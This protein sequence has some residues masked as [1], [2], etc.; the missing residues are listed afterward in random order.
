MLTFAN[1]GLFYLTLAGTGR[2]ERCPRFCICDNIKHSVACVNKNLTQVPVTIPQ[3]TNKL[4]IHDNNIEMIPGGAFRPIP[5]LTHLNMQKCKIE[6]IEEGAFRGLGRLV[7]LNLAFNNIA[8]I[9][10]E[11]FDGLSFL[12]QLVLEKNRLEEIKPGAFSQLGFLNLLNLGDNFLV[13]LPDMIFQGLQQVKWICLSNNTLNIV[14]DQAFV[15][16]PTLKRLSLDHNEL[17]YLPTEALSKLSGVI[18]LD[19]G[20]NPLTFIGEEAVQMDSLKQ[21]F[22]NDMALQDVSHK[23]FEKSPS[24]SLID[25]QNNQLKVMQPLTGLKQIKMVNLTG[26]PIHCNCYMRPFK[27]WADKS[28]IQANIV[29]SSPISF[30]GEHLESL[31]AIDLKCAS[32]ILEVEEDH[33]PAPT[34]STEESTPCPQNCFC[35]PDLLHVSCENQGH[36]KIPKGFS[37]NTHLLDLR[38]NKFHTVPKNSFSDMKNLVSLHLQNCHI[39]KLQPGAFLGM[40]KMIY[41]YLSN[42]KISAINSAAFEGIPQLTYLYLDHNRFPKVP[43]EAFKLL[44]NLFALHLQYNSIS[45]LSDD[46]MS[47]AEKLHWL[48]LTGN[49]IK[50]VAP[51]ALCGIEGLEKLHLDE[52]LLSEIP[53]SSLLNLPMLEELKLS[54]NPIK[55]IGNGTFLPLA[56]SLQHL[57]LDNLGLEKIAAGAFAGIGPGIRRLYLE[58]NKLPNLPSMNNFTRL[59]VINLDNNPFVCNCQLLPLRRWIDKLNLKVGATCELPANVHG[60]R[61]KDILFKTCLR[62]KKEKPKPTIQKVTNNKKLTKRKR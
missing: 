33:V 58:N 53:T 34:M 11:S 51:L 47:G 18:R 40:R 7:Y 14:A 31:R 12:Q 62:W 29:C 56:S 27:E 19:L 54:K 1:L 50:Y 60:Q 45:F 44:P 59:E 57:Y 24:L 20:W 13:Y 42:N 22:L 15:G 49:N 37:A 17:Q 39:T 23:A 2:S 5:Y 35:R 4:D 32:N 28:R 43:K 16:L 9:Y 21:L 25:F 52:N 30:R 55:Y 3:L 36:H 8:F 41:L 6:S 48:Y 61:V 46:N 26:N 38:W 10:Q